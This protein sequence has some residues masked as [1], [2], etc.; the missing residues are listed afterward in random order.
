MK[1]IAL[2]LNCFFAFLIFSCSNTKTDSSE[3]ETINMEEEMPAEISENGPERIETPDFK[4]KDYYVSEEELTRSRE[5]IEKID[6]SESNSNNSTF[7]SL[8]HKW[9]MKNVSVNGES[10]TDMSP[11]EVGAMKFKSNKTFELSDKTGIIEKGFWRFKSPK[12]VYIATGG[13]VMPLQI[14]F[15]SKDSLQ[16][17]ATED[18]ENMVISYSIQAPLK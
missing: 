15:I 4:S 14:D 6:D 10:Q 13:E 9:Y 18:S 2:F 12:T 7:R 8:C 11:K 1:P 16:L 17:S 5:A 3:T